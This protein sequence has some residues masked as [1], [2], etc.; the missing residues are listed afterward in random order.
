[1]RFWQYPFET[2]RNIQDL[3]SVYGFV[4]TQPVLE[5]RLAWLMHW[6]RQCQS[7]GINKHQLLELLPSS[8]PRSS[9]SAITATFAAEGELGSNS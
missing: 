9:N 2:M 8:V 3:I 5:P 4:A 1:M 6:R 7:K